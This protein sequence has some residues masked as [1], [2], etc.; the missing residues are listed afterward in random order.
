[1]YQISHPQE[2]EIELDEK[3]DAIDVFVL[4]FGES[5]V[6]R[7]IRAMTKAEFVYDTSELCQLYKRLKELFSLTH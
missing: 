3:E 1:M 7:E 2:I 4:D 6:I 5:K